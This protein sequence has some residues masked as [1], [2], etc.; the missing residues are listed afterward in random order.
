V[1]GSVEDVQGRIDTYSPLLAL[2]LDIEEGGEITLPIPTNFNAF[3]YQLDGESEVN[4]ELATSKDLVWF[5][6]DGDAVSIKGLKSGKAIL[7]AG[8][9][10]GEPLATYGPFVMNTEAELTAAIQDYQAGKMGVL[11]EGFKA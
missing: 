3:V 10:I 2:R 9:P 11:K 5:N 4:G 1:A 6:N 7:L 8:E